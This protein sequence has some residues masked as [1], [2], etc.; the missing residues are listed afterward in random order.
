VTEPAHAVDQQRSFANH[1]NLRRIGPNRARTTIAIQHIAFRNR[2]E[3]RDGR[4]VGLAIWLKT[5]SR[6]MNFIS[7][8]SVLGLRR[9]GPG[10]REPKQGKRD[11]RS[12]WFHMRDAGSLPKTISAAR[13]RE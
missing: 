12:A 7:A 9:R 11:E 5:W 6:D 2:R 8:V 13:R 10:A 3:R 1:R 4:V